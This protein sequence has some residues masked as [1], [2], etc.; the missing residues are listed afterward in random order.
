MLDTDAV[1][2]VFF[3]NLI[4][5]TYLSGRHIK[6]LIGSTYEAPD[7]V[8]ILSPLLRFWGL[9]F[10]IQGFKLRVGSPTY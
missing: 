7:R 8:D 4:G 3:I 2:A 1:W 10:E 9:E 6:L 5:P